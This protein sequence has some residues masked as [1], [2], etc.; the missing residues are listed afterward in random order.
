M[1]ISIMIMTCTFI[2]TGC[3]EINLGT[4]DTYFGNA[5]NDSCSD[6]VEA[7]N[8]IGAKLTYVTDWQTDVLDAAKETSA[9]LDA[10]KSVSFSSTTDTD[11]SSVNYNVNGS[12]SSLDLSGSFTI[13]PELAVRDICA[14]YYVAMYDT[15]K[16][17]DD[18]LNCFSFDSNDGKA[19]ITINGGKYASYSAAD[20]LA[21]KDTYGISD[22]TGGNGG[23]LKITVDSAVEGFIFKDGILDTRREAKNANNKTTCFGVNFD[24]T[25]QSD[26]AITV[27]IDVKRALVLLAPKS[28]TFFFGTTRGSSS[29][30]WGQWG[31]TDGLDCPSLSDLDPNSN[32]IEIHSDDILACFNYDKTCSTLSEYDKYIIPTTTKK[33]EVKDILEDI[34]NIRSIYNSKVYTE[35]DVNDIYCLKATVGGHD[36]QVEGRAGDETGKYS[37]TIFRDGKAIFCM[38]IYCD[39]NSYKY[40][41]LSIDKEVYANSK[42][43][44]ASTTPFR[45]LANTKMSK[46][47]AIL[48]S[49]GQGK[50][51]TLKPSANLDE[52]R[53]F[54]AST[55]ASAVESF[56]NCYQDSNIERKLIYDSSVKLDSSMLDSEEKQIELNCGKVKMGYLSK[57][58][59]N[60]DYIATLTGDTDVTHG[61]MYKVIKVGT[62]VRLYLMR[63][64]VLRVDKV[65]YKTAGDNYKFSVS[66][67]GM[68]TDIANSMNLFLSGDNA[69]SAYSR[70]ISNVYM[71][72]DK[73]IAWIQSSEGKAL[74]YIGTAI[75][76]NDLA[77]NSSGTVNSTVKAQYKTNGMAK[78]YTYM[79]L[80]DYLEGIYYPNQYDNEDVIALGRRIRLDAN[81]LK[82]SIGYSSVIGSL[83]SAMKNPSTGLDA[84]VV[85]ISDLMEAKVGSTTNTTVNTNTGIH[86]SGLDN[87]M[88]GYGLSSLLTEYAAANSADSI[89]KTD[90]AIGGSLTTKIVNS[91]NTT[92][93]VEITA[94]AFTTNTKVSSIILSGIYADTNTNC[95]VT[96]EG[97]TIQLKIDACDTIGK[98]TIKV[99][100]TNAGNISYVSFNIGQESD[101]ATATVSG[102]VVLASSAHSANTVGNAI[103]TSGDATNYRRLYSNTIAVTELKTVG[104]TSSSSN[105][106]AHAEAGIKSSDKLPKLFVMGHL[107]NALDTKFKSSWMTETADRDVDG[108]GNL[109][110]W[111]AW[112]KDRGYEHYPVDLDN[113]ESSIK[114]LLKGVQRVYNFSRLDEDSSI[115]FD[116]AVIEYIQDDIDDQKLREEAGKI[117]SYMVIAGILI[118][119]YGILLMVAWTIDAG[120]AGEGE[121]FL[122]AVSFKKMRTA[123]DMSR[124]EAIG[125]STEGYKYVTF[126]MIL[127]RV[128]IL[129][130]LSIVLMIVNPITIV[131]RLI[132][133]ISGIVKTIKETLFNQ[134]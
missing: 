13:I 24:A 38:E 112:L 33:S 108:D 66:R 23:T 63:Y 106:L 45:L 78:A 52:V 118:A 102:P 32:F 16:A 36:Y 2:L 93:T 28:G 86:W 98:G 18:Y 44:S 113:L 95:L 125:M 51:Y 9:R 105:K 27:D 91:S 83:S 132:S 114:D 131:S 121:G 26:S 35:F 89:T 117:R 88:V 42:G 127:T 67:S 53:G 81:A 100:L 64:P 40:G 20:L 116:P 134:R 123:T 72:D 96:S 5:I 14:G 87:M 29:G 65:S 57:V 10:V 19:V 99:T 39:G 84:S 21:K 94:D 34:I 119:F 128:I 61:A 70:M 31:L 62:E 41:I 46:L 1:L 12:S 4:I 3:G 58:G 48:I 115:T 130:A 90:S 76:I 129:I 92:G 109:R 11:L 79:V 97:E 101:T 50:V 82:G 103:G 8:S 104:G 85:C 122:Y 68:W 22:A 59:F 25:A 60:L 110:M 126:S 77:T 80:L 30:D 6:D 54:L 47:N 107:M 15:F 133:F 7:L 124:E 49:C 75:S 71:Y 37:G 17:Y 120:T 56:K 69:N 43:Q 73:S 74:E 55:D 111:C